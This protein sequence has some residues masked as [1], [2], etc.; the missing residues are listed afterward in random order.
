MSRSTVLLC[1]SHIFR[2]SSVPYTFCNVHRKNTHTQSLILKGIL[3]SFQQR[4]LRLETSL[5]RTEY[6]WHWYHSSSTLRDT[7]YKFHWLFFCHQDKLYTWLLR[8]QTGFLLDREDIPWHPPLA[9]RFPN[10]KWNSM[11]RHHF[12]RMRSRL[13]IFDNFLAHNYNHIQ[14]RK[15]RVCDLS[16]TIPTFY[17]LCMKQRPLM[18]WRI[19]RHM[20]YNQLLPSVADRFLLDRPHILCHGGKIVP[21]VATV[22]SM[23]QRNGA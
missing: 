19:H 2:S 1:R 23:S 22:I 6:K 4:F 13:D 10:R 21:G 8:D 7:F 3:R 20:E 16:L 18:N 9:D 5:D 11:S 15:Y 17:M 14:R 12:D